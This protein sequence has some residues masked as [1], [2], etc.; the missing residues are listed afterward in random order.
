METDS[1]SDELSGNESDF[2]DS[3]GESSS[4]ESMDEDYD[5]GG[6]DSDD[7]NNGCCRW[8]TTRSIAPN[9]ILPDGY[10]QEYG[11]PSR[12]YADGT[13]P[14]DIVEEVADNTFFLDSILATN[15]HGY[16]D[17]RFINEFGNDGIPT[18][19]K[20]IALM[21]GFFAIK[22][23][24]KLKGVKQVEWA[25]SNDPLKEESEVKKI[26]HFKR[27]QLILKHYR[28]VKQSV[29]P[30]KT[31]AQYHPLQ[32]IRSGVEYL[33]KKSNELWIPGEKLV[34]DEGRVRS[35]S[36]RNP[37][38]IRNVEKPIRMG[39]T[40]PKLATKGTHGGFFTSNHIVKVGKKTYHREPTKGKNYYIVEHLIQDYKNQ[41]R[42]LVIDS[43]FP[44]INLLRDAKL[45]WGTRVIATQRG[46]TSHL[47]KS[48]AANVKTAKSF[49]RGY[50]KTLHS[51][52]GITLTYWNDNSPVTFLDIEPETEVPIV[53]NQGRDQIAI[54]VPTVAKLYREMYG[55][56]DR[57]NQ[58]LSYYSMEFRSVRKQSRV[59]DSMFE[60]Y[61]IMNPYVVWKNSLNL[62]ANVSTRN[63][64]IS[65]FRFNL[66]RIWFA[67]CRQM[68]GSDNSLH[69]RIS[70]PKQRKP[71]A[72]TLLS[73][74]KGN[75]IVSFLFLLPSSSLN[76]KQFN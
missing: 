46:N 65:E 52:E 21:K 2:F 5:P 68:N 12:V 72:S 3:G 23:F 39:W 15:E 59:F 35:K 49:A 67:V 1:E 61:A 62:T 40:I 48:H 73:P 71:L 76:V 66:V 29:L 56:V 11:R 42:L 58:H 57:S 74:R 55:W 43:G 45:L 10:L 8:S 75:F 44:T 9:S 37:Y 25:W 24:L 31:S 33:R 60:T 34:I 28:I 50:S 69:Y 30:H 19:D 7:D 53:V 14:S 16:S 36:K 18:D 32:N 20:G 26:M 38:K 27:F 41:G 70:C 6:I 47:P 13:E 17:Q 64:S 22:I 51:N 54:N 63:L 4:D